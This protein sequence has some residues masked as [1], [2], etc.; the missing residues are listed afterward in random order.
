MPQIRLRP[1]MAGTMG[2]DGRSVKV[3]TKIDCD[4][5]HGVTKPKI[6]PDRTG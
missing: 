5:A 6:S 2:E 4:S 1:F 3:P